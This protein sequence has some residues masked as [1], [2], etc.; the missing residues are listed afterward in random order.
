MK[1]RAQSGMPCGRAVAVRQPVVVSASRRCDIP[2]FYAD[3]FFARLRAGCSAC[4]NPFNGRWSC[5]SYAATRFIVFWSKN[6]APLLAHLDE[7]RERGIGCYIQYTLNDYGREGLEGGVP[8]LEQRLDTFL[9]LAD[10]LGPERVVWRVD[11]LMISDRLGADELLER[12][13][14]IGDRLH[15]ATERLV[16]S[17]ADIAAYGKVRRRLAASGGGWR[18]WTLPEMRCFAR[19][20]AALNGRWGYRLMTCAEA[21]DLSAWGIEHGRCVDDRLIARLAHD[22]APL[23]AA[24]GLAVECDG[25]ELFGGTS[26]AVGET[27]WAGDGVRVRRVR[28]PAASGQRTGCGCAASVD[29][30]AYDTCPH[31]C[32]YC[33]ATSSAE[34]VAANRLRHAGCPEGGTLTG[35][36][37]FPDAACG[38]MKH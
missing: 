7:L 6:P 18:E 13:A 23:M 38:G 1:E 26:A 17:F 22:D 15:G 5:V 30:G 11:P 34:R 21:V 16:F 9:R 8:P 14:R 32:A 24:L 33:Y 3:W 19:E 10:R 37:P 27:V 2:A 28:R 12:V 25:A 29:V 31:G 20:L 35:E 36:E 4:R